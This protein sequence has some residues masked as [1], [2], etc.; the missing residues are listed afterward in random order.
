MAFDYFMNKSL[1]LY[2]LHVC[3]S[4][5]EFYGA[6]RS[7]SFKIALL[8]SRLL[9]LAFVIIE[10]FTFLFTK[11]DDYTQWLVE[12]KIS[13]LQPLDGFIQITTTEPD[14]IT[15]DDDPQS[16][17]AK[18][19]CGHVIGKVCFNFECSALQACYEIRHTCRPRL[20][21]V[22]SH[23]SMFMKSAASLS[24]MWF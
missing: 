10:L 14:M 17:R 4:L 5:D 8:G 15:Y 3:Y 11:P 12:Q 18:M 7:I 13:N 24:T 20:N 23:L 22:I 2:V 19:P 21:Q 1:S 9:G 16:K 6:I